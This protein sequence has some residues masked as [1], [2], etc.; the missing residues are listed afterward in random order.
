MAATRLAAVPTVGEELGREDEEPGYR[1]AVSGLVPFDGCTVPGDD[2]GVVRV[3]RRQALRVRPLERA[4]GERLV[5]PGEDI[6]VS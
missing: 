1:V 3:F 2:L 4:V 6:R 5:H